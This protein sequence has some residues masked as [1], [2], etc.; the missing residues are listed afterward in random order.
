MSVFKENAPALS[1]RTLL[2]T[3]GTGAL[4][5]AGLAAARPATAALADVE[6][7]T[8][9]I[10][11][12]GKA[13]EGKVTVD[14]PEIAENGNTVPITVEVESPMTRDSYVKTVHVF[15]DGNP[16]PEVAN[17][18]FTPNSGKAYAKF[19]IRLA[20]TQKVHAV[21]EMSDGSVWTG[22]KEIK[23]TIGGCGG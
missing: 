18:H 9:K 11:N 14:G 12:G 15:A 4:A 17:F 19:R 20:R 7:A 3:A 1:R 21:A 23:V 10:A 22:G 16:Q 5:L 8:K 6:A 2:T 13:T